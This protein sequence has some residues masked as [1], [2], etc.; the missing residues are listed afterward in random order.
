MRDKLDLIM[1]A[2]STKDIVPALTHVAFTGNGW[3]MAYDGRVGVGVRS[4]VE[5]CVTVPAQRLLRALDLCGPAAVVTTDAAH[6]HVRA[7]GVRAR[8]QH[9]PLSAYPVLDIPDTQAPAF[10]PSILTALREVRP[11][12]GNDASRPWSCGVLLRDGVAYATDNVTLARTPC[13]DLGFACVLPAFAVDALHHVERLLNAPPVRY[14]AAPNMLR[15]MWAD[16]TFVQTQL[17]HNG[18]PVDVDAY[19]P[20][21]TNYTAS[22]DVP[23]TAAADMEKLMHMCPDVRDPVVVFDG[24][25]MRTRD[26]EAD[27]VVEGYVF[28][29][30]AFRAE[31]LLRVLR[32]ARRMHWTGGGP[33]GWEGSAL[34]GALAALRA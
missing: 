17:F 16:D 22:H 11:F 33:V 27:A 30:C 13:A 8:I 9:H 24:A 19:I 20:Q 29:A 1:P 28:P 14:T 26:G 4:D 3:M 31:P 23:A 32:V 21:V 34:V 6:M 12:V 2:V 5:A 18:W 25:C 7:G 10:D 15:F